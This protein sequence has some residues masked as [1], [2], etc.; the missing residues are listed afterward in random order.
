VLEC[1]VSGGH[2]PP[3]DLGARGAW[4]RNPDADLPAGKIRMAGKDY[5][6]ADGDVVEFRT[7]LTSKSNK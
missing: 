1:L 7:G 4:R 2:P 6:M 5:L 3:R